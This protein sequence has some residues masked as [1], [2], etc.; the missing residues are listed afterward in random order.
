MIFKE[1]V[2]LSVRTQERVIRPRIFRILKKQKQK[3]MK[4]K[5][6]PDNVSCSKCHKVYKY[7]RNLQRHLK[8][9]CGLN[10]RFKCPYCNYCSKQYTPIYSHIRRR[11]LGQEVRYIDLKA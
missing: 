11:H 9:E 6:I 10:P 5:R 3:L 4:N 1:E 2:E 7:S 8:F